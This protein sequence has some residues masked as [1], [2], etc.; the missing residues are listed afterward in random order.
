ML[1]RAKIRRSLHYQTA[2]RNPGVAL[3]RGNTFCRPSGKV[4]FLQ[5]SGKGYS[6]QSTWGE[7]QQ[8]FDPADKPGLSSWLL[9]PMQPWS[10]FI[11]C[12]KLP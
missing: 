7:G 12:A 6:R 11:N 3:S 5:C 1:L 9:R 4:L 2:H 8:L 10:S